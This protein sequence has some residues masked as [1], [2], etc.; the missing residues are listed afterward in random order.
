M[1]MMNKTVTSA[2]ELSDEDLFRLAP[3]IFANSAHSSRS[4]KFTPIPTSALITRMRKEGF[5]PVAARQSKTRDESRHEFTKHMVRFRRPDQ[6]ILKMNEVF[7]ET[8]L[9]NANDGS[10]SYALMSGLWRVRCLNGLIISESAG[11]SVRVPHKGDIMGDV[12]EGS[13]RV[14]ELSNKALNA[15]E[16]WSNIDLHRDEQEALALSAAVVRF[17][18]D[19]GNMKVEVD[20]REMLKVRRPDDRDNSLWMTFNRLQESAI[21]GG[22]EAKNKESGR[23]RRSRAVNGIDGD[24]R[25][26]RGLWLLG[27]MM[28][29]LKSA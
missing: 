8:I 24:V 25:V 17:G 18:D 10:S 9:L 4:E 22:V 20:P 14:M 1:G 26:N 13:Y 15:A 16:N 7:P 3:S 27:E 12:I 5:I 6:M 28:A 11:P 21:K 23:H 2:V 29:K 19:Q